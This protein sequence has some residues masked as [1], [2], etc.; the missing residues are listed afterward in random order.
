MY[1][2]D[3]ISYKLFRLRNL[4]DKFDGKS[5]E[6]F[7]ILSSDPIFVSLEQ[8]GKTP[9]ETLYSWQNGAKS[10]LCNFSQDGREQ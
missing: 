8:D 3:D 2:L 5:K 7:S 4:R 9:M 10:L 6:N 1:Q